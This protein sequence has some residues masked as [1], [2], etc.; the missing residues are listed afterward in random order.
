MKLSCF[1][2]V[3]GET[4]LAFSAR[5]G[6]SHTTVSRWLNGRA[7]PQREAIRRI[8]AATDGMVTADDFLD[9]EN[10]TSDVASSSVVSPEAS[11]AA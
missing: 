2:R 1:L 11:E 10:E 8:R 6:V 9:A 4:A 7:Y 5:V 3:S